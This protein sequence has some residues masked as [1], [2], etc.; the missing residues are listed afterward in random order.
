MFP[1]WLFSFIPYHLVQGNLTA[2][3]RGKDLEDGAKTVEFLF[4]VI[5]VCSEDQL[6]F[7]FWSPVASTPPIIVANEGLYIL[8]RFPIKDVL[9]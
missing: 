4:G 2:A 8:E 7:F 1:C 3:A 9:L 5:F 6:F